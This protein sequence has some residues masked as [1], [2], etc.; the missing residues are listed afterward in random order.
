MNQTI[1]HLAKSKKGVE[2]LVKMQT[3]ASNE[4]YTEFQYNT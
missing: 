3:V 4:L 2:Q 1:A